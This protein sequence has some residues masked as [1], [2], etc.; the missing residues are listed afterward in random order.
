MDEKERRHWIKNCLREYYEEDKKI[1]IDISTM[2]IVSITYILYNLIFFGNKILISKQTLNEITRIST[3]KPNSKREEILIKNA[4][5]ILQAIQRQK[6]EG[7]KNFEIVEENIDV[8]SFLEQGPNNIFCLSNYNLYDEL[9]G[10][11]LR[12]KLLFV[13][14]GIQE[15]NP[16]KSDRIKFETIGAIGF[17][18]GKMFIHPKGENLIKVY[19]KRGVEKEGEILEVK[20]GDYVLIRGVKDGYYSFNLYEVVSRHTRNHAVRL[21]WSKLKIGEKT[22]KYIESL[23][24]EYSK[25]IYDNLN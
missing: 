24:Y 25:I 4:G 8:K 18:D 7:Y 21:I 15:T 6:I 22:N 9:N 10:Y 3:Q 23:P 2:Q 16:H 19:N 1:L 12:H 14:K 20:P 13:E 17:E 11:G 5:Y